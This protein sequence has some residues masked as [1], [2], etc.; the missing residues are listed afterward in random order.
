MTTAEAAAVGNAIR[1]AN[2]P[3]V[4][5]VAENTSRLVR[6]D[7]G[8]KLEPALASCV[9]T[10][11]GRSESTRRRP[12]ER[13]HDRCEQHRGRVE[14]HHGGHRDR[15]ERDRDQ[16]APHRGVGAPR[17]ELARPLEEP[18]GT[19]RLGD[20][21]DRREEDERGQQSIEHVDGVV[22]R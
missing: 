1:T 3:K 8:N 6:F 13:D 16:E 12:H 2:P 5:P 9:V 22:E 14:A 4:N 7:T 20:H 11:S 10:I 15:G 18:G 21:E 17:Q 19:H